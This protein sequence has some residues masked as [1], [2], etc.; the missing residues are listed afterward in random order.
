MFSFIRRSPSQ[1]P[2]ITTSVLYDLS[3]DSPSVPPVEQHPKSE[4]ETGTEDEKEETVAVPNG[5]KRPVYTIRVDKTMYGYKTNY[6]SAVRLAKRIQKRLR[7]KIA[8]FDRVYEWQDWQPSI[9]GYDN[10]VYHCTLVSW[11]MN[12]LMRVQRKEHEVIIERAPYVH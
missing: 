3:D 2:S 1:E 6:Y 8:N 12:F 11:H 7:Q 5:A 4:D 10:I 9:S